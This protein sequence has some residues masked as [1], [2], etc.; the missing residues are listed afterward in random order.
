MKSVVDLQ[1]NK[2]QNQINSTNS[3]LHF[4]ALSVQ[5]KK[6][7]LQVIH[8]NPVKVRFC[9]DI[10]IPGSACLVDETHLFNKKMRRLQPKFCGSIQRILLRKNIFLCYFLFLNIV[11]PEGQ[12][13]LCRYLQKKNYLVKLA[14]C[15]YVTDLDPEWLVKKIK[16]NKRE[17]RV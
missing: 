11:T 2:Y 6:I 16:H 9:F 5:K 10:H 7:L 14:Q 13:V 15:K 8:T 12:D 17:I 3:S 4:Y 1:R